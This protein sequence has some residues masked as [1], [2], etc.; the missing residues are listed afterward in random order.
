MQIILWAVEGGNKFLPW[1]LKV[2]NTIKTKMPPRREG[3]LH[4]YQGLQGEQLL[5][6]FSLRVNKH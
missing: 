2:R 5:V 4:R 1:I 3:S 6:L